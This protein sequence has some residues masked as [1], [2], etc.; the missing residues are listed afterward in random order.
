[1]YEVSQKTIN[2]FSQNRPELVIQ[3]AA[4]YLG[5]DEEGQEKLRTILLA[6]GINKWL[7]VRRDLIAHKINI[8]NRIKSKMVEV[9]GIKCEMDSREF[10]SP[11]WY[12]CHSE[13]K[14]ARAELKLLQDERGVLVKMC[15]SDRFVEWPRSTS[16]KCTK[17]MNTIKVMK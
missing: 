2:N 12:Y 10:R 5:L 9:A 7:A 17:Q 3:D 16:K 8:K 1:M 6:R 15:K 13:W 11:G 14:R 4:R